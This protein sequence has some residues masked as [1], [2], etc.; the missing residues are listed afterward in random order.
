MLDKN[1][2]WKFEPRRWYFDPEPGVIDQHVDGTIS[3]LLNI[4]LIMAQVQDEALSLSKTI[5]F[6]ESRSTQH[7]LPNSTEFL[8][9]KME[10]VRQRIEQVRYTIFSYSL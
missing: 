10:K 5:F 3:E 7:T 8:L 6:T 4:Y 1:Y 9:T 2:A